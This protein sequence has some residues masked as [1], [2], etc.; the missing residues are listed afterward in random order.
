MGGADPF[1]VRGRPGLKAEGGLEFFMGAIW[2]LVED[3]ERGLVNAV[4]P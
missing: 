3:A 4:L 1:G 2:S